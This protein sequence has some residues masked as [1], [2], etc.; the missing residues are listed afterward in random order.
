MIRLFGLQQE[1]MKRE[2]DLSE[3]KDNV[4]L[5]LGGGERIVLVG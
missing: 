3:R 2:V 5:G 4:K 1:A